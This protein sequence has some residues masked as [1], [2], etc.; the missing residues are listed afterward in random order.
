MGSLRSAEE[1]GLSICDELLGH[2]SMARYL[3]AGYTVLTLSGS[4]TIS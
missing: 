3:E 4:G 1:Q 2:P